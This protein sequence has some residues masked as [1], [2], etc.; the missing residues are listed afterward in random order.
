MSGRPGR[1]SDRIAT[2]AVLSMA[3]GTVGSS[4]EAGPLSSADSKGDRMGLARPDLLWRQPLGEEGV[5]LRD[6]KRF[7]EIV[8]H[9]RVQ[10]AGAIVMRH[11]SISSTESATSWLTGSS[12]ARRMWASVRTRVLS[13]EGAAWHATR[14][15]TY[16]AQR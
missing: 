13:C 11:P 16:F 3:T 14:F 1:W 9:A 12:L 15:R 2:Q 4:E 5:E 7:G 6:G 8:V 10:A